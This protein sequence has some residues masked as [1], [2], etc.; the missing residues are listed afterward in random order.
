MLFRVKTTSSSDIHRELDIADQI[1]YR[2]PSARGA[3][4]MSVLVV[5]A[6]DRTVSSS[7]HV[8]MTTAASSPCYSTTNPLNL[9]GP[10]TMSG[11]GDSVQ[12]GDGARVARL[13]R[14]ARPEARL[15]YGIEV[16]G[17]GGFA[18]CS[19]GPRA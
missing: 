4:R 16:P 14:V 19:R 3:R 5:L 7:G 11:I 6:R 13:H 17:V 15:D 8:E 10:M 18:R 12:A 1:C 2:G 9:T